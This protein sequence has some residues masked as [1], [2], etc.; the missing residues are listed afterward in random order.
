MR[1]KGIGRVCKVRRCAGA[2]R[3]ASS[4]VCLKMAAML[5]SALSVFLFGIATNFACLR[6]CHQAAALVAH[7]DSDGTPSSSFARLAAPRKE[8]EKL[9]DTKSVKTSEPVVSAHC[10]AISD[11]VESLFSAS[12]FRRPPRLI[13][14]LKIFSTVIPPP[15]RLIKNILLKRCPSGTFLRL[16]TIPQGYSAKQIQTG[17]TRKMV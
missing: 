17:I 16:T 9:R 5:M 4:G 1:T 3:Y 11:N 13:K 8:K 14:E 6:E 15:R 12:T 7:N 2:S 10:P